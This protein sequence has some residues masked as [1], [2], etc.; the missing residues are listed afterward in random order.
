MGLNMQQVNA[1][2]SGPAKHKATMNVCLFTDSFLPKIGGMELVVH[3]LANALQAQGCRVTVIAK[4]FKGKLSFPRDYVI[5]RYGNRI[6]FS[7]RSGYDALAGIAALLRAHHRNAF[8]VIHCHGASYAASRVYMAKCSGLLRRPIIITPHGED[9]QM[10]PELGYGLRL[11]KKWDRIIR[12]NLTAADRVTAI[13]TTISNQLDFIPPEKIAMIP[14]GIFMSDFDTQAM[15]D[16]HRRLGLAPEDKIVLS[17]G[18]HHRVKG[19]AYGVHTFNILRQLPEAQHLKYVI[20]GKDVERLTSS[21]K[22]MHLQRTVF[23]IPHMDREDIVRAYASAWCFLS[24][25]LSEGL[26]LVS[27]EAMACGLPLIVTDVPGN[28]D[29]V[30]DNGC[31]MIVAAKEPRQIADALLHLMA[32]ADAHEQFRQ[33]A[34]QRAPIYDWG[35]IAARYI[36]LYRQIAPENA[37]AGVQARVARPGV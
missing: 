1:I 19:Y 27:L 25:S 34:L 13:S 33:R 22:E 17:V 4:Y 15:H 37:S 2:S 32:H 24:P 14:N 28:A 29:I 20:I 30:S 5:C 26:S 23:A 9:I 18:R 12:R 8:D 35:V 21:I 6:P 3:N 31:G 7:G 36:A 10:V 16:L 11:Q